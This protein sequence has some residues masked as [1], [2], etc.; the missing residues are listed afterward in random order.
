M[1]DL[2]STKLFYYHVADKHRTYSPLKHLFKPDA[3]TAIPEIEI[4]DGMRILDV[5]CGNGKLIFAMSDILHDFQFDGIDISESKIN[6]CNRKNK[7]DNVAFHV[8]S[9]DS[10]PFDDNTFDVVT[11]C[12]AVHLIPQKVKSIDEIHR[13]L[14]EGGKMYLLAGISKMSWKQ[15]LEKILRQTKFIRPLKKYLPRSAIF[16]KSFFVIAT[17]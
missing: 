8:S 11:F 17:K 3:R 9:A 2:H 6:R 7:N 10:M 14:K 1:A 4:K 15:K 5:A 12:N 13:V 16:S